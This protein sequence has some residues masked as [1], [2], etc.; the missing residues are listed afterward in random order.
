MSAVRRLHQ[1]TTQRAA[2]HVHFQSIQSLPAAQN[3]F[4]HRF[5]PLTTHGIAQGQIR[6]GGQFAFAGFGHIPQNMGEGF[7][8]SVMA[9]GVGNHLQAGQR[10]QLGL[11]GGHLFEGNDR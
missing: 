2:Q 9:L 8:L 5:Q 7:A 4:Q 3:G 1:S 6:V 10:N 11:N